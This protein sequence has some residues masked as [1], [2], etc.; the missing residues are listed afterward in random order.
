M[1]DGS[2]GSLTRSGGE[3]LPWPDRGTRRS[4]MLANE[5]NRILTKDENCPDGFR[6]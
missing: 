3:L 4:D 1:E 2:G 6:E 5:L